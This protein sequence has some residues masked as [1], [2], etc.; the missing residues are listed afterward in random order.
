MAERGTDPGHSGEVP[1]EF[2]QPLELSGDMAVPFPRPHCGE[3]ARG[4]L[5]RPALGLTAL[6]VAGPGTWKSEGG[7]GCAG[8]NR[9]D[10]AA[11]SGSKKGQG[12]VGTAWSQGP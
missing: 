9:S 10:R 5:G 7:G 4:C 8:L 6:G 1:P 2:G 12:G 3:C 11:C